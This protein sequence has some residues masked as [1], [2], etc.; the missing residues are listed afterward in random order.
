M[1]RII[2]FSGCTYFNSKFDSMTFIA[3]LSYHVSIISPTQLRLL[4]QYKKNEYLIC[5]AQ[6]TVFPSI[7]TNSV[8]VKEGVASPLN[9][10][11]GIKRVYIPSYN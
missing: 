9:D 10:I 8:H 6:N 7:Y 5:L 11:K 1:C 4:S 3:I 2:I